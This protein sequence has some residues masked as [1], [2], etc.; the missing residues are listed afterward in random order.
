MK[1]LVF[2]FICYIFMALSWSR[3][4]VKGTT[5]HGYSKETDHAVDKMLLALEETLRRFGHVNND[6]YNFMFSESHNTTN[7]LLLRSFIAL[8]KK[9]LANDFA[10][11]EL[12]LFGEY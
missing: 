12:R 4:L 7:G 5:H 1:N 10:I 6:N 9:T 2:V 11:D 8:T 3:N